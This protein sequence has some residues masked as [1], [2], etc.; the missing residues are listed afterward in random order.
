MKNPIFEYIHK[1]LQNTYKDYK[2]E[3]RESPSIVGSYDF[4]IETGT[5]RIIITFKRST[6]DDYKENDIVDFLETQELQIRKALSN[7]MDT[8]F[9]I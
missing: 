6:W 7:N 9:L 1:Y 2:I 8:T 3:Y 5:A 4:A